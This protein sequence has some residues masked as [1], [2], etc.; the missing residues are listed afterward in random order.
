MRDRPAD[1][2]GASSCVDHS[3][4]LQLGQQRQQRQAE[5]GEVVALDALEELDAEALDLDRR[6]RLA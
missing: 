1:D 5:D 2:T 6:R 4:R 3:A